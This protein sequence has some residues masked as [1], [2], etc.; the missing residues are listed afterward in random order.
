VE[1]TRTKGETMRKELEEKV[2]KYEKLAGEI[3]NDLVLYLGYGGEC[4]CDDREEIDLISSREPERIIE[5]WCGN[6]GGVIWDREL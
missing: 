4:N 2:I 1:N 6:C 5:R 3:R